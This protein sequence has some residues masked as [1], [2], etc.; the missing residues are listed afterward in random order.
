M[1][2]VWTLFLLPVLVVADDKTRA[3]KLDGTYTVVSGEHAGKAIPEAEIQGSV[4]T[5]TGDRIVGTDKDR[6]EFFAATYMVDTTAKPMKIVM[7]STAPKAGEKAAGIIQ[8]EGDTIK[9]A[10]NLPGG[11]AP[12][13][14]KTGAKQ[15]MFVLKRTA[16]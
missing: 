9:L 14:F 15:H 3:G 7:T 13:D 1:R 8:V 11:E 5:F 4:V 10:Y 6:K 2:C 16:K 12:T